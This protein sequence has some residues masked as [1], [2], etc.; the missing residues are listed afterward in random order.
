MPHRR[1]FLASTAGAVGA[2]SVGVLG[3]GACTTKE[4]L[5]GGGAMSTD[6][7]SLPPESLAAVQAALAS[8]SNLSPDALARDEEFWAEVRRAYAYDPEVLNL[9]HG[10]TN[11]IMHAALDKLVHDA[12]WL[13]AL[14][15]ERLPGLW[16][17]VT[18]TT[19]RA[20]LA[21]TLGVPPSEIAL[22]RNATEALN[23]V[24]LGFPMQA[25]DEVVCS[26]HDYYATLDALEQRRDRD[27]I[28]LRMV[29]PPLPA[30]NGDDI[31]RLYEQAIGERTRLVLVTNPSNLTGQLLPVARIAAAARRA[32]ARVVVDGAQSL[33]L[34]EGSVRDLDADFYGAS[35]HKW[36][37]TPVGLGVLWMRPEHVSTVW[38]LVPPAPGTTGMERFEWIGTAPEYVNPAA[39]PALSMQEA[40]TASRKSRR[41]RF[42]WHHWRDGVASALPLARFSVTDEA[43][44]LSLCT[45]T[46]PGL[47]HAVAAR[48][49]REEHRIL[50]QHMTPTM[51]APEVDAIRVTPNVFT[52]PAELD[53]FVE[54]LIGIAGTPA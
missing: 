10:W 26:A 34:L 27:G 40:L 22:V 47:D 9:D 53:R 51:R 37:G 30:A 25:G 16:E 21:G 35:A 48:R 17:S 44:F 23:T 14:P 50:V 15:A 11:P 49:L 29:R 43:G 41:L 28:V 1:A 6:G 13:H 7:E 31:A 20:A 18:T 33:G 42:L 24:L 38:P 32:G 45:V 39:L 2:L 46:V 5:P 3:L 12:R 54:A 52:T 36:L 8:R 19:V 4:T